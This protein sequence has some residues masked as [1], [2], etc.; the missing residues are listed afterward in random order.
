MSE[1]LDPRKA[2]VFRWFYYSI[3]MVIALICL[4]FGREL[5]QKSCGDSNNLW[6]S[7]LAG[8]G[9]LKIAMPILEF[10]LLLFF[11]LLREPDEGEA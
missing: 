4:G 9:M 10:V 6:L 1:E 7:G 11:R 2:T 3:G 8:Y 5:A